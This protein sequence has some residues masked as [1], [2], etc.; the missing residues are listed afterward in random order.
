MKQQDTQTYVTTRVARMSQLPAIVGL[1]PSTIYR[2]IAEG[3]FPKP[4]KI[5]GGRAAGWT[6]EALEQW[7]QESEAAK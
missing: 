6:I 5:C 7:L 2:L 1:A 3:R 4:F